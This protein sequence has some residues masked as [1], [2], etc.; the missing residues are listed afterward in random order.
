MEDLGSGALVDLAPYGVPGEPVVAERIERGADVVTFSGDKL[1]G[2]PQAGIA[3]G[4]A[5]IVD[6]MRRNPLKRALRC[7]KLTLAAL[8]ATLRLYRGSPDLAAALPTLRILARPL[9]DIE[10]TGRAAAQ[11][12]AAS[13]GSDY[14]IEL[15]DSEAEVGS[16]AAPT[17]KVAS[18]A[19]AIRH[20]RVPPL[21]IAARFRAARPPILGRVHDDRFLLD[22]RCIQT[23][24]DL[25]PR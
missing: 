23:P 22:L 4:R 15:V 13:L 5:A 17:R 18:K 8:E 3:V 14:G 10:E 11:L 1:L 19:L 2:G 6:R 9:D 24:A 16:G 20:P 25:V 21:E 12:L 7:D